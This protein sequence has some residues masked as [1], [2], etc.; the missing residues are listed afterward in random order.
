MQKSGHCSGDST[1]RFTNHV[2]EYLKGRPGYPTEIISLLERQCGLT[3]PSVVV[4]VGCGTGLLAKLF[5]ERGSRVIGVEPN[6]LRETGW[7]YLSGY[8][9]F[10]MLESRLDVVPEESVPYFYPAE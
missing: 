10:E 5:C 1:V 2:D 7:H 4:D 9:N 6:A 8:S 3:P